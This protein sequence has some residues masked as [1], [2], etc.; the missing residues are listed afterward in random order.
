[1]ALLEVLSQ[2]YP[3]KYCT[4]KTAFWVLFGGD[5]IVTFV[6]HTSETIQ[7]GMRLSVYYYH[8]TPLLPCK[9]HFFDSVAFS[10]P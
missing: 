5:T 1:M 6:P 7:R 8:F 2:L 10:Q 4:V 3:W 9:Q